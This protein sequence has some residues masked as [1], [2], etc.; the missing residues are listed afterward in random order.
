M[1]LGRPSTHVLTD[2]GNEPECGI[3]TDAVNLREVRSG[4]CVERGANL[5]AW[6]VFVGSGL[7]SWRREGSSLLS[8]LGLK[9]AE[10]LFDL[11]ITIRDL[12][13]ELVVELQGLLQNEEMLGAV[14]ADSDS[15]IIATEALH[16]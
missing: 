8:R 16:R 2:L 1:L 14:V 5:K 12:A 4:N 7:A 10:N 6:L 13:L 11:A 15:A 9:L 3:R